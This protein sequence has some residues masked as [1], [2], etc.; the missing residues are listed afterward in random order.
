M[1]GEPDEV[2]TVSI[3]AGAAGSFAPEALMTAAAR[4]GATVLRT[5]SGPQ[6]LSFLVPAAQ[7]GALLR[8]LHALLGAASLTGDAEWRQYA[9]SG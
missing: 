4:A 3:V 1:D 9:S 7:G 2:A 8:A 6:G 5:A